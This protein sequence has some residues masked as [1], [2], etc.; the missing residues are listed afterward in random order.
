MNT[1]IFSSKRQLIFHV[2]INGQ[3]RI[4]NFGERSQ[5]GVSLFQTSDGKTAE[6]I[7][8]SSMFKR[9]IIEENSI[10]TE[11]PKTKNVQTPTPKKVAAA[12]AAQA[13]EQTPDQSGTQPLTVDQSGSTEN[14]IEVK[15]FTQAKSVLS[16][17][18]GIAFNEIKTPDQLA[19]MAKDA[20]LTFVYCK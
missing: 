3:R 13:P 6:A 10:I 8:N 5:S 11:K 15:T 4:V 20:G 1:Y 18:L 16:K 9:G 19:Q 7:R 12:P 14:V 2:T 17:K